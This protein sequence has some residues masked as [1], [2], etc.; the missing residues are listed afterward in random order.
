MVLDTPLSV[1][2]WKA[3]WCRTCHSNGDLVRR[4]EDP[5]DVLRHAGR[6][7]TTPRLATSSMSASE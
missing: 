4:H 6:P 3:P 1:D 2:F 5:L 7:W